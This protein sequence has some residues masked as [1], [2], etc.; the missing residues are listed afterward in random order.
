MDPRSA[1][2]DSVI[3]TSH[4]G[5]RCTS[6]STVTDIVGDG[7]DGNGAFWY[8]GYTGEGLEQCLD[9]VGVT[10]GG[11]TVVS[12]AVWEDVHAHLPPQSQVVFLGKHLLSRF[13]KLPEFVM[14]LS[15]QRLSQREFPP[16]V[17]LVT[18]EPG[19]RS[20]P[21]PSKGV[22]IM[23]TKAVPPEGISYQVLHRSISLYTS[24]VRRLLRDFNGHECKEPDPGKFTLAF[25]DLLSALAFACTLQQE[26]SRQP[27]PA[28]LI[29]LPGCQK[30]TDPEN[31]TR[32]ISCGLPVS[33]GCAYG[34]QTHCCFR[35][36][37][38]TTGR[39]DYFGP[40]PNLTARVLGQAKPGQVLVEGDLS[41]LK[42]KSLFVSSDT[43]DGNN[44]LCIVTEDRDIVCKSRG[45]VTLKGIYDLKQVYSVS[46]PEL[47][48]RKF[49]APKGLVIAQLNNGSMSGPNKTLRHG[50]SV[51]SS[52][53]LDS[54]K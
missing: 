39:P 41:S 7:E 30:V 20:A 15:C 4:E 46:Y 52:I 43:G 29:T 50:T 38:K 54:L 11:Q 14:E 44:T 45:F 35:K 32:V 6:E 51:A 2:L 31:D 27:W 25:H 53:D 42:A 13:S 12:E 24:L 1:Y 36:A 18:I 28:K 5:L 33:I 34:D 48:N 16:L 40:L 3:E 19:Y 37:L 47:A 49:E 23:F 10:C 22:A 17:S 8:H 9:L 26:L 21:L